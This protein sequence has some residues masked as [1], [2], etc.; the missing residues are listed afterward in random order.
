MEQ[1]AQNRTPVH[2][3]ALLQMVWL[4]PRTSSALVVENQDAGSKKSAGLE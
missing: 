1:G 2:I 3:N 4:S